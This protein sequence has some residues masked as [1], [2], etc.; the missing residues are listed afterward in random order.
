MIEKELCAAKIGW[1][2]PLSA[3]NARVWFDW[4]NDLEKVN[5]F[6]FPRYYLSDIT[7]KIKSLRLVGFGDSSQKCY[8]CIVYLVTET[9]SG[10]YVSL[11]ASKTRLLPLRPISIPR[12]ELLASL[13]FST[14][15]LDRC[16]GI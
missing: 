10:Q 3:E 9:D 6:S 12:L 7:G 4:I 8:A 15:Y 2:D 11:V 13:N 5:S 1:D 14:P 16:K